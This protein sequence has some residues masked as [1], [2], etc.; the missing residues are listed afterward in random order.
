MSSDKK[1]RRLQELGG[2]DYKIVDGEPNIKGWDVKDETGKKIGEVDELI[3]DTQTR[4]VRYI[5]VDLE[6]N[7]FDFDTRDVLVPIGIAQLH[8]KDDDV[9][10]PGVT[11]EQIRSLPDYDEDDLGSEVETKVRNVFG[12]I[13]AAGA[14]G[15][16]YAAGSTK[17]DDDVS[18]RET[19]T[20]GEREN[21]FY[22]HPHFD[23]N[24][25]YGKR[26]GLSNENRSTS[27]DENTTVP[28]I[29]ENIEIGKEEVERGGIRLRSRIVENEVK[30]D[31]NLREENVNVERTAVDRPASEADIKEREIEMLQTK[32]VPV[33]NKEARVVEEVSLNKEV[34]EREETVRDTVRNTDVDIEKLDRKDD[35]SGK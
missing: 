1:E 18:S 9:I 25:F 31:V 4:K 7:V 2:S 22:S 17:T 10:L 28:I 6:G 29:K 15:A 19:T 35:V 16:A 11:A 23:D 24:K 26:E 30:K 32:E 27:T 20:T 33:V 21:D 12:G 14:A 8:E 34:N 3:F 13:G 5:V